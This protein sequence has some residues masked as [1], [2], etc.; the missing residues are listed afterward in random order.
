M[1]K[2]ILPVADQAQVRAY[3][4]RLTLKY[5]RDL[6]IALGLHGL[7][8]VA[9]LAAPW[10]LGGLVEGVQAGTGVDVTGV[11][12]GIGGFLAAQAVLVRF[13]VYASSSWARRSSPSCARSSSAGC[14]ACRCPRS[15][16]PDP[17][18]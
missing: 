7:A 14:S 16:A 8:A 18:T 1:S 3:A 2:Q 17:A 13:A 6:S 10:L 9:G 11:S 4:R 15:S 12:L 5:P